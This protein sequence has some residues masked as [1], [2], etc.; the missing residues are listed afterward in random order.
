[1]VSWLIHL[2][3]LMF[4]LVSL[5][6]QMVM[7]DKYNLMYVKF[8]GMSVAD[9]SKLRDQL[10]SEQT[11]YTVVKKTLWTRAVNAVGIKGEAPA[12]GEELAVI[13]GELRTPVSTLLAV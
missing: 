8:K 1:M 9:T 12:I 5:N 11:H 4:N 7:Y 10:F 2:I 6:I 3:N 13:Y